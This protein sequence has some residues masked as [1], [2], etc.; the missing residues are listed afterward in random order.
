MRKSKMKYFDQRGVAMVLEV[1][2]VAVVLAVSGL[3]I[4]AYVHAKKPTAS[5]SGT[6]PTLSRSA[7]PSPT[8][9]PTPVAT[10]AAN[11][12]DVAQLGFKMTLPNGLTGLTDNVEMNQP[13]S[14]GGQ[15]YTVST[16]SFST[17]ALEQA[18]PSCSASSGPIGSISLYSFNPVGKIGG[19]SSA[20]V[21]QLGTKYLVV[22]GSGAECSSNAAASTLQSQMSSLFA[23]AF[24]SASPL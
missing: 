16:A 7:T 10:K 13:G 12:F 5:V 23:Q 15:T 17:K 8:S 19:I 3:G 24:N 2:I 9:T 22:S 1:V 21:K 6:T 14:Y 11:E 18:A 4:Y 20:S